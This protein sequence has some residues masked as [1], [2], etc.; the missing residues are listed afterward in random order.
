MTNQPKE[1]LAV[2]VAYLYFNTEFSRM[3]KLKH[4]HEIFGKVHHHSTE[5]TIC[6]VFKVY[7]DLH[8]AQSSSR[9]HDTQTE[10]TIQNIHAHLPR[11]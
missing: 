3:P 1:N 7:M 6:L 8:V 2:R 4:S 10:E 5:A 11:V 9:E